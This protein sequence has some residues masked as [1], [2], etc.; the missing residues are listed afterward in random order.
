MQNG[1]FSLPL[2]PN[3]TVLSYA[4]GSPEKIRLKEVLSQL[5]QETLDVPMY[6]GDREVRT[7]NKVAIRPP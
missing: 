4:P 1:H 6:I 5:K 7:G 2:P 3:E